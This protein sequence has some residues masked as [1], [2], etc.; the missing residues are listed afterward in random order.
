MSFGVIY[1]MA[2]FGG[3][4]VLRLAIFIATAMGHANHRHLEHV[5]FCRPDGRALR[6]QYAEWLG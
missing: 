6:H 1:P 2:L 3:S 5:S 4:A